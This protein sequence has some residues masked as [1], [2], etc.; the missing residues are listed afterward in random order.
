[1]LKNLKTGSNQVVFVIKYNT[2]APASIA[3]TNAIIIPNPIAKPFENLL[4]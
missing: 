1:M 2:H 4:T 3:S